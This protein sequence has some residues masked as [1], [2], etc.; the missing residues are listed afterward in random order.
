MHAYTV[1]CGFE[2][3][4]YPPHEVIRVEHG[5]LRRLRYALAAKSHYVGKSLYYHE[6]VARKAA[7]LDMSLALHHGAVGQELRKEI[8]AADRACA[9]AA[10]AVRRCEGL[11]QIHV[12]AVEA[13]VAGAYN[14]HYR[15]EVC[16]VIVAEA[17]CL[18]Y[19]TGYLK[20]VF[21]EY[22][23][24]IGVSQHKA[25]SIVAKDRLQRL[26]IHAAVGGGGDIYHLIAAHRRR[27]GVGAVGGIGND[28]LV[29]LG[30]P[31]TVVVLLDEQHAGELAVGACGGLE[32]HI[33]H[34]GD[35]AKVLAYGVEHFPAAFGGVPGGEWVNG[36][37]AW[38][39]GH[40]L[41]NAGVI[42]HGAG[43]QRI[44]AAVH[45]V[46]PVVQLGIVA[47]NVGLAHFGQR[48]FYFTPELLWELDGLHI[49][50]GQY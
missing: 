25:G 12:Y 11:V 46:Y 24:R 19:E 29:A 20:Y 30:I 13:H 26:E 49:A 32:G 18:V 39:R 16:A 50:L 8:L 1:E 45:A 38:Q 23:Y 27:G 2:G 31:P 21:I 34:S 22:A 9:R 28:Y 33:R 44:K 47:G 10:A 14:A 5:V 48:G 41:V 4:L 15:V 36:R 6:E 3:A 17:A 35:L 37:K 42:F 7:Y 40:L 43:A